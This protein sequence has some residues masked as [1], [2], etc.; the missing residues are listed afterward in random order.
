MPSIFTKI[1]AGEIPGEFVFRDNLW[2]AILDIT[3]VSPGHALLIPTVEAQYL[4]D[5]PGPA[6]AVLGDRLARLMA[7][8]R[9]ASGASDVC[10]LL[11]DGPAAG[12]VVPH[13][14]IHVFPRFPGD[15]KHLGWP[16]APYA[17]GDLKVW[18]AKVRSAWR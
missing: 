13:V 16:A 15:N 8:V 4:A 12:Q 1:I 18:A 11:K 7:A 5:V 6:M 10:V 3:P 14:H 17:D 2:V 9:S